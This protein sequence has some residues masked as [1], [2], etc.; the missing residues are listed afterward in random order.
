MVEQ[1]GPTICTTTTFKRRV[2]YLLYR[3]H[4]EEAGLCSVFDDLCTLVLRAHDNILAHFDAQLLKNGVTRGGEEDARS[5]TDMR[6]R[7]RIDG[8]EIAESPDARDASAG[9]RR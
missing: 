1:A 8:L 4:D 6:G 2:D 5:P 3:A 9:R 7:M